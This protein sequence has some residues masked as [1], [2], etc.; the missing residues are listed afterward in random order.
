MRSLTPTLLAAQRS[1]SALPFAQV[2]VTDTLAGTPRLTWT[3]LYTGAE[4]DYFHAATIPG[5]GSLVRAR[6]S[7][8]DY[9]LYRQ[10]VAS[11]GPGSDFGTWTPAADVSSQSDT[12]LASRDG[13]VLLFSVTQDQHTIHVRESADYGANF[14]SPVNVVTIESSVR[15]LAAAIKSDGTVLLVYSTMSPAA[16]WGV[17]RTGPGWGMPFVWPYSASDITG[18]ACLHTGDWGIVVAGVDTS[19]NARLWAVVLGDG[20]AY[21]QGT[22]SPL[23]TVAQASAGSGVAFRAPF[24]SAGAPLRLTF[25]ETYTGQAPYSRPALS[26]TV[27][28]SSFAQDLWR[29]PSPFNLASSYGMS[30]ALTTSHAW[31]STPAGVWQAPLAATPLDLTADVVD[32]R[33]TAEPFAGALRVALR[34]DDS[35]Y[36]S[37][38][39]GA[40]AALNRGAEVQASPGY[41][42]AAGPEVSSGPAFWLEGWEHISEG[43]QAQLVLHAGDAW[44]LLDRW[45]ARYQYAWAA[46]EASV[47]DILAYLLGR[48]GL[49]LQATSS[50]AALTTLKPAFTLH[51]NEKGS[52]AVRRLL[53][54]VP[55]VLYFRGSTGYLRNIQASDAA[56]YAYGTEHAIREGSY[57]TRCRRANRVQAYGDGIMSESF[58]WEEVEGVYERLR[59]VQDKNLASAEDAQARCAAELRREELAAVSGDLLAHPNCGQELYDVV[60]VTDARAGLSAARRRVL[61]LDLRYVRS[62]RHGRYSQKLTLGGV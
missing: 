56:D 31:L 51:P 21:P 54:L 52:S 7:S 2:Q 46:G 16:V 26:H 36:S 6:V 50:S 11:P 32:L 12:A 33:L 4:P 1:T 48:A 38:G 9:R 57:A 59:Q 18:L 17:K 3:R 19:S 25:V 61:G 23:K 27:P 60:E 44:G 10:R 58:A 62:G 53:T 14:G 37:P 42:T 41:E 30:L 39:S 49:A 35:R 24:L 34:N 13:Q 55:D 40:L 47:L 8:T 28:G 29:E 22:W 5:D 15:W 20:S 45:A 43:G